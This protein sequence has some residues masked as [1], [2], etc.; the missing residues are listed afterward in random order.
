MRAGR[1]GG[2]GITGSCLRGQ[3]R[4]G[5]TAA[6]LSGAWLTLMSPAMLCL[7]NARQAKAGGKAKA[8]AVRKGGASGSRPLGSTG[9]CRTRWRGVRYDPRRDMWAACLHY[10]GCVD[11]CG[12][13]SRSVGK[14]HDVWEW[15]A[16]SLLAVGLAAPMTDSLCADGLVVELCGYSDQTSFVWV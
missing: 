10:G 8:A 3:T 7:I 2:S 11:D 16:V 15:G 1:H 5:R 14:F 4:V 12:L 13:H 9:D 6:R